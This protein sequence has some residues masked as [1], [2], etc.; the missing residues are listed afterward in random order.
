MRKNF[1]LLLVLY[2]GGSMASYAQETAAALEHS[3]EQLRSSIGLWNVTTELLNPDGTVA[4]SLDGTYE[5]AWVVPDR[6]VSGKSLVP[7]QNQVSA[8]LFYVSER[9]HIIEMLSVGA[10][11]NLWI[12]TGPLGGEERRT[13]V[14]KTQGGGSGQLKFTRYN[15]LPDSFESKMEYTEDGGKT[16]TPGNHQVF[17][18]SSH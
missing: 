9:K 18:R 16:W 5:F 17:R 11:G 15:V 3:I 10:D 2:L 4:D 13:Q 7:S 8:L 14:F 6:V 12:M 1:L